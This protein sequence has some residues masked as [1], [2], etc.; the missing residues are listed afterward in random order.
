MNEDIKTMSRV[1]LV[2]NGMKVVLQNELKESRREYT[3][4][5]LVSQN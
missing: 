2:R 3:K 4:S 1:S 5:E